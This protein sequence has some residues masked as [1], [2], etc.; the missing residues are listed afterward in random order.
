MSGVGYNAEW[1]REGN[2]LKFTILD[3]SE[4]NGR[5]PN[6]T[7][8]ANKTDTIGGMQFT[9]NAYIPDRYM[10]ASSDYNTSWLIHGN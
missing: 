1:V 10:S 7:R 9:L 2:I 4:T 6:S 3:L 8:V 5:G